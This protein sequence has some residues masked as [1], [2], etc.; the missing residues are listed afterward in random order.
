MNTFIDLT[1]DRELAPYAPLLPAGT[2]Y[3]RLPIRDLG[4]PHTRLHMSDIL[5]AIDDALARGG[6]ETK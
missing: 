5:N 6:G 2:E 3:R 4:V 1:E